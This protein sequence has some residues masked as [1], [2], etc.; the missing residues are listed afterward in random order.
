MLVS[1][2]RHLRQRAEI[3]WTQ[4]P[5]WLIVS[6]LVL[7]GAVLRFY[8]IESNGL[9]LDEAWSLWMVKHSTVDIVRKIWFESGDATPPTYYVLLHGFISLGDGLVALRALSVIAG[10]LTVWL[11]FR[12]AADLFGPRAA[13]LSA[14]LVAIAPLQIEYSQ[15]AR[16]YALAQL[17]DVLSL[18]FLARLLLGD[19]QRRNWVGSGAPHEVGNG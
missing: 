14:F 6:P 2:V 12:L 10:A 8:R 17:L 4:A 11:V 19:G 18:Y 5:A 3:A 1:S 7:L 16:A 15:E 9:N 13:A